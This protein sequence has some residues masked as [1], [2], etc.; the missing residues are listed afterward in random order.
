MD[1]GGIFKKPIHPCR[2]RAA[3]NMDLETPG[4]PAQE[5]QRNHGIAEMVEFNDEQSGFHK[6]FLTAPRRP[7]RSNLD[8]GLTENKS[9]SV[10]VVARLQ[11]HQGAILDLVNQAMLLVDA[12]GPPTG[13]F[14]HK[15]LRFSGSREWRP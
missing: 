9:P 12:A 15:R 13:E 5:R 14:A 11:N 7:R 4:R 8:S 6:K 2:L 10:V 1:R 3:K